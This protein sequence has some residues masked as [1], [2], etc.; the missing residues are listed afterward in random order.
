MHTSTV[1]NKIWAVYKSGMGTLGRV[2]GDLGLGTYRS[3][4][5]DLGTLSMG[6]GNVKY[7]D[8]LDVGMGMIIAKVRG[9]EKKETKLS[10]ISILRTPKC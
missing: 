8:A 3:E 9:N 5:K 10:G 4:V 1:Y 6:C 7:R 2:C